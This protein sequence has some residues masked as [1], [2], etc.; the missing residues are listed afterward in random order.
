MEVRSDL[1][2]TPAP[3]SVTYGQ[4]EAAL[5][6][7]PVNLLPEVYAYLQ[8]LAED[9][10]DLATIEARQNEPTRPIEEFFAELDAKEHKD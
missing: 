7:L 6:A 3:V 5:K 9:A 1:R 8:E 2:A 4:V 10:A